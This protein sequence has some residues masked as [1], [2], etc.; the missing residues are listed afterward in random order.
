ML[1]HHIIHGK[2]DSVLLRILLSFILVGSTYKQSSLHFLSYQ[3][4]FWY[5]CVVRLLFI[6]RLGQKREHQVDVTA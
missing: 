6:I 1:I 5:C 2:L 3:S 4:N